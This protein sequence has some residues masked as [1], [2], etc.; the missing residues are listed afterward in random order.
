MIT[1]DGASAAGRFVQDATLEGAPL[2]T[3]WVTDA[4]LGLVPSSPSSQP[5]TL[6]FEMGAMPS[7]WGAGSTPPSA[8]TDPLQAWGCAA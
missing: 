5:T 7:D 6:S 3:T 1:A 4:Q 2:D 8:S